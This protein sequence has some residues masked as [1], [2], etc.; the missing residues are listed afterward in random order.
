[1]LFTYN[2]ECR[3]L[4]MRCIRLHLPFCMP[5]VV[6]VS[7][8]NVRRIH[9]ALFISCI[10]WLTAT[11]KESFN[12]FCKLSLYKTVLYTCPA[13]FVSFFALRHSFHATF[14]PIVSN[15]LLDF[16]ESLL[17]ASAI[18]SFLLLILV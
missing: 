9:F 12:L 15:S 8:T 1:M 16:A 10:K 3:Y 14:L 18:S 11:H 5:S 6:N 7:A 17:V 2:V 13:I 4:I